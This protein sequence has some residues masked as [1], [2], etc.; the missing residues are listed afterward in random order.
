MRIGEQWVGLDDHGGGRCLS[1][2]P[3]ATSRSKGGGVPFYKGRSER[4]DSGK[5]MENTA[6]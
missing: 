1:A 4:S 2:L 3:L 6:P 5:V